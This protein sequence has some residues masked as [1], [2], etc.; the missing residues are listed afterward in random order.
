MGKVAFFS[1]YSQLNRQN[2]RGKEI[3]CVNGA[4]LLQFL[5]HILEVN[6]LKVHFCGIAQS[7]SCRQ[8]QS[9]KG[10]FSRYPAL[11]TFITK[12]VMADSSCVPCVKNLTGANPITVSGVLYLAMFS[13]KPCLQNGSEYGETTSPGVA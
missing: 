3:N 10:P 11:G 6:S 1:I 13:H 4:D 5:P 8:N 7:F 9:C 12:A 2:H